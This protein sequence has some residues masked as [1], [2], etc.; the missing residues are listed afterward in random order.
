MII[1]DFKIDAEPQGT[2]NG[3]WY[4]IT[5]GGYIKPEEVLDN[6]DQIKKLKEAIE[7]VQS[8]EEALEENGLLN[9]F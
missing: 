2:S 4:D 5:M 8:F 6:K 9:E 7:L 3:F 1:W